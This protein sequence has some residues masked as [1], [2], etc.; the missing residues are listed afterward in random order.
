MERWRMLQLAEDLDSKRAYLDKLDF[1]Q[2]TDLSHY[3][4]ATAILVGMFTNCVPFLPVELQSPLS[5]AIRLHTNMDNR[6][7]LSGERYAGAA[8]EEGG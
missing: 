6:C 2:L 8:R 7:D 3:G 5:E 4:E 1:A